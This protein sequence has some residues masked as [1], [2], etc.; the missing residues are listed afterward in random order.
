MKQSVKSKQHVEYSVATETETH[1][2]TK[3]AFTILD[4]CKIELFWFY[5][6]F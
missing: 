5:I 6:R 4:L 2:Y 3:Q 1:F